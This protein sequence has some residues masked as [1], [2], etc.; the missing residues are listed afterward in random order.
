[1]WTKVVKVVPTVELVEAAP[2][3]DSLGPDPTLD[4]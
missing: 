2:E 3:E 1:M 4:F